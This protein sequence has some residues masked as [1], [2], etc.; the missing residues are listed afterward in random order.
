M[1]YSMVYEKDITI[2]ALS[3]WA[4]SNGCPR[5]FIANVFTLNISGFSNY[6]GPPKYIRMKGESNPAN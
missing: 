5:L 1:G 3:N 2:N 4:I 6:E